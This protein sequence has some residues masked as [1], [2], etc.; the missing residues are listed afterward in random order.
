MRAVLILALAAACGS[1]AQ[2]DPRLALLQSWGDKIILPGYRD[3]EARAA[4]LR[5]VAIALCAAPSLANLENA[6]AT[7]SEARAPWKELEILAFG[8]HN[9]EPLRLGPKID[10]WPVRPE[11]IDEVLADT[12]PI[13]GESL[14]A[15]AK[16]FPVIEY[17]L[18]QPQTDVVADM[19]AA[20]RRCEYLEAIAE[21]LFVRATQLREAWDPDQGNYLG[22]LVNAGE[23]AGMFED[24]NAAVSEIVNRM[25]FAVE[26]IRSDKLGTPLGT[27]SGGS[28]QPDKAESQFSGRSLDDIRDNLRGIE[29]FYFGDGDDEASGL[30]FYTPGD[31]GFAQIVSE[32]LAAARALIDDI[33]MPLAL[34][35][36]QQPDKVQ[37]LIDQLVDLQRVIQ[38]DLMNALGLTPRFNDND[39]D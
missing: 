8:P 31:Q 32:Q 28:P 10:F 35:V 6:Q 13:D 24:R 27:T 29:R 12:A 7:W 33:G 4:L 26:D 39:G 11:G 37:A 36:V 38:V 5:D 16:G 30:D 34:A 3:F 17:L 22:Q 1:G 2:D 23:D 15:A 19:M 9:D 25:A 14:G 20:P 18:Y 21:D